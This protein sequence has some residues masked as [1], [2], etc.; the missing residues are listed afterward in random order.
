MVAAAAF[1]VTLP[2]RTAPELATAIN[3]TITRHGPA[4]S[5]QTVIAAFQ[6]FDREIQGRLDVRDNPIEGIHLIEVTGSG[7]DRTLARGPL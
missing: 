4:A 1:D 6:T 2:T 3:D 7:D 5:D